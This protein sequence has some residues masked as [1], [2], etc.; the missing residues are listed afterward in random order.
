MKQKKWLKNKR[1]VRDLYDGSIIKDKE[2][3]SLKNI[4]MVIEK[5]GKDYKFLI[6][7]FVFLFILNVYNS[8][9][10]TLS[11]DLSIT[12]NLFMFISFLFLCTI[13]YI[14]GYLKAIVP[15]CTVSGLFIFILGLISLISGSAAGI[16]WVISLLI[17]VLGLVFL[18]II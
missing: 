4:D 15:L 1:V 8:Y 5:E 13:I 3:I 11:L 6:L 16:N 10:L 12:R 18:L 7:L 2:A 17:S 14:F 9:A